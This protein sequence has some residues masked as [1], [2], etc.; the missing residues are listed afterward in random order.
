M[1][2]GALSGAASLFK[3]RNRL[4]NRIDEHLK[5]YAPPSEG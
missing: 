3:F 4:G 1:G 5:N 2:G